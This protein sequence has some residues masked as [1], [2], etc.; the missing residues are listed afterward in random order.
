VG[1]VET[2]IIGGGIAGLACARRLHDAGRE[3]VLVTDR[4]GGRMHHAPGTGAPFGTTYVTADYTATRPY[5]PPGPRVRRRDLHFP[6]ADRLVTLLHPRTFRH[7]RA[8]GRLLLAV[9]DFRL[10]LNRLRAAAPFVC[11]AEL[12]RRDPVLARHAAEPAAEYIRANGL[13]AVDE[14]Y[15]GPVVHSTVFAPP[16]R[17][18]TFYYLACL[19]PVL[20]PTYLADLTGAVDRLTRGYADR[21]ISDRV[22]SLEE[23]RGGF[24][25]RAT[26][27]EF[28]ARN[29]VVATPARNTAAFCPEL[30]CAP[31]DGMR[32][33]A[34]ST[35]HVAGRR[36]PEYRP[37]KT[38]FLRPGEP[39]TVL[40]PW[41]GSGLD[42]LFSPTP[43]PDLSR[44]YEGWRVVGRAAWK[45]A[46]LLSG[47][48]WR[49][50]EARPG[51]FAVGDHNVCGLEDSFLTGLFAANRIL[52]GRSHEAERVAAG[53]H[54]V[55][56]QVCV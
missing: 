18:N 5:V 8:L 29:V 51:L 44:Y 17:L 35:L 55:A 53:V 26:A 48:A 41:P 38:V 50:L 49:P 13:G 6:D 56:G 30:G 34:F 2:V 52:A 37:G 19:Q 45:T 12:L 36:R 25:V 32:D 27:C 28:A 3:F 43:D 33:V 40:F 10:R 22:V 14:V 7:R 42:V 21:V 16:E 47:A 1:S 31:G 20:V 24:A 39:A 4:L 15:A 46:V 23:R 54:R 9:A 11:Q